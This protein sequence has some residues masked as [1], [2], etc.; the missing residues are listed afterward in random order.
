MAVCEGPYGR[1]DPVP[2]LSV[3][4]RKRCSVVL[5]SQFN[6]MRNIWNV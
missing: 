6:Y 1:F 5:H 3:I 4:W 2:E